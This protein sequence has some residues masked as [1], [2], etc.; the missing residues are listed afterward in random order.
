M[1]LF[2]AA[3]CTKKLAEGIPMTCPVIFNMIFVM[4]VELET[5]FNK[6]PWYFRCLHMQIILIFG[7][8]LSFRFFLF[9][10]VL[11]EHNQQILIGIDKGVSQTSISFVIPWLCL[12]TSSA[13]SPLLWFRSTVPW[14]HTMKL[15]LDW[16]SEAACAMLFTCTVRLRSRGLHGTPLVE[17]AQWTHGIPSQF[18]HLLCCLPLI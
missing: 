6:L 3:W 11:P 13:I 4:H 15:V 12:I 16:A 17:K 1:Y 5:F 10:A 9:P 18:S 14:L 2:F 8:G 7:L